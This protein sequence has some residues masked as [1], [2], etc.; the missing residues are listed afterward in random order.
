VWTAASS[1]ISCDV[2]ARRSSHATSACRTGHGE[3]AASLA[4]MST[5]YWARLEQQRAPQPSEQILGA[6]ARALRL[7]LD[8]RDHLFRLAGR[9]APDRLGSSD[10]VHP[11]LMRVLDRLDDTPAQVVTE[12]GETLVQ[13][14]GARALVGDQTAFVGLERSAVHRWFAGDGSERARYA[15]RDHDGLGRVWTADL[16]AVAGRPDGGRARVLA[17]DL[18]GRSAEF[19]AIWDEH[20]VAVHREQRKTLVHPELGEIELDCQV[21]HSHDAGQRLLVF[22]ATPGTAD[23]E[24]LRLLSVVGMQF[25]C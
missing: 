19:A 20:E 5:D 22:T 13:N 16:R 8:E 14:R 3:E 2:D 1:G 24:K 9:T 11:A 15:A 17:R 23:D 4:E 7:T 18:R 21:L 25:A 12:L 10:H 6:M